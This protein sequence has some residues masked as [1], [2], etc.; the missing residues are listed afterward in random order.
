MVHW[1]VIAI[2]EHIA[3]EE[4]LAGGGKAVSIDKPADGGVIIT[5]LQVIESGFLGAVLAGTDILGT[6]PQHGG[7]VSA[8]GMI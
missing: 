2:R 7:G 4:A 8:P 6:F 1:V 3:A 5:G